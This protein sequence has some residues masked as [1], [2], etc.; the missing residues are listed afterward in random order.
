MLNLHATVLLLKKNK[1]YA[2]TSNMGYQ[3]SLHA[4]KEEV[5]DR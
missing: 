3:H 2:Q 5:F 4:Q 1:N